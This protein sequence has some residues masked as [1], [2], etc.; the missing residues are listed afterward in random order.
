MSD[1]PINQLIE[2]ILNQGITPVLQKIEKELG[3]SLITDVVVQM[4]GVDG[5]RILIG[6]DEE[7]EPTPDGEL[8]LQVREAFGKGRYLY[9]MESVYSRSTSDTGF[10]GFTAKGEVKLSESGVM[11]VTTKGFTVRYNVW[12]F[13]G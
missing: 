1:S 8:R 2:T 10:S 12:E 5:P 9:S 3:R 13:I 4:N 7:P 11:I 6:G